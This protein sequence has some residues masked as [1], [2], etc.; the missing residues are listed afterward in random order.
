MFAEPFVYEANPVLELL[1]D[2]LE[3]GHGTD[4][5]LGRRKPV[6]EAD[7]HDVGSV[8]PRGSGQRNGGGVNQSGRG[9]GA[10]A[11]LDY[12]GRVEIDQR[13]LSG[14]RYASERDKEG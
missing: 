1:G 2:V 8:R 10:A 3:S 13:L 7:K 5:G 14:G 4:V 11:Y 12:A 9:L 6:A